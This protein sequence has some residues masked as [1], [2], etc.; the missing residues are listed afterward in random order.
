V[1]DA[2]VVARSMGIVLDT[3]IVEYALFERMA[4][5]EQIE[6]ETAAREFLASATAAL[7]PTTSSRTA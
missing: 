5:N 4:R 1:G 7:K 6:A 2:I 3:A